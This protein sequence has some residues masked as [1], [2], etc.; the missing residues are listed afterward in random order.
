VQLKYHLRNPRFDVKVVWI[1]R[2]GRAVARSLMQNERLTMRQAAGEW[3]RF[4]D[5]ADAIVRRLDRSQW[6]QVHYEALCND[7]D[8]TLGGLWRFMG[9]RPPEAQAAAPSRELHVLGHYTRL[10]GAAHM[11]LKEKWRTELSP[12]DLQVFE[13]LAGPANRSLGYT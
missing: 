7:R 13:A 10:N 5:E 2:D 8:G 1:V 11:K 9:L 12:P 4:H 6:R 3:R